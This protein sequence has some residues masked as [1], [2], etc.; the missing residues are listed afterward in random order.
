[1]TK[2]RKENNMKIRLEVKTSDEVLKDVLVEDNESAFYKEIGDVLPKLKADI[3]TTLFV[4]SDLGSA[5]FYLG[6]RGTYIENGVQLPSMYVTEKYNDIE[7]LGPAAYPD[8]YLTCIHPESNNYKFYWL[9]PNAAGIG[10]TYGRIG[11]KRGEAFGT[12][13]LVNPYPNHLYWIRYYEKISKGYIDQTDIYLNDQKTK[14]VKKSKS[15]SDEKKKELQASYELYE[16]LRAYAKHVVKTTLTNEHVTIAQ[17]KAAKKILREMGK[18]KTVKGFNNQLMKLMQIA[19]RKERY[20]QRLLAITE[21]DFANII[22]REEN[23]IAAMEAVAMSDETVCDTANEC[24]ANDGIEVYYATEKQKKEVMSHLSDHLKGK[25]YK[26]YRVINQKHKKRFDEYLKKEGI[27]KVKQ[28]WHGSRNENWFSIVENG[29]QLNPNAIITGKMFGNGIYF[30]PSS[31]KSWNYTS[32][33]G[34][35]WASGNSDTG[36]MGLYAT[37][38]G[39]PYDVTSSASY[40][41]RIVKSHG[42]DCVHAHAGVQLLNDEIIFYSESAMLLNYIV[43]FK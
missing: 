26:V 19:P 30:A 35:S 12:K 38:Y 24:F 17:V 22:Y 41:Q 36:F 15:I 14:K 8:A 32:Y 13:D 3:P 42:C 5:E 10:A 33:Q 31:N 40:S 6:K 18:R 11:S 1:M 34:T 4:D 27:K 7:G 23:L 43:E 20:I 29:L 21:N 39:K 28:L 16:I 37:A 9:R 2:E 25:V